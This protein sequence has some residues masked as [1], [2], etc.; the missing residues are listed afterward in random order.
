MAVGLVGG[1]GAE[2]SGAFYAV[3]FCGDEVVGP[4]LDPFGGS[5]TTILA[6][7]RTGRIARVVELDPRCVDVAVRRWDKLT[8]I[9]ARHANTGLTFTEAEARQQTSSPSSIVSQ[10]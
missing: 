10:Q 5:G 3:E 9:Q 7:E 6:A 2:V 1:E 8:G 4:I